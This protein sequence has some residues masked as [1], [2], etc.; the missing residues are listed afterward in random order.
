VACGI[1]KITYDLLLFAAF[2]A[3]PA[4]GERAA[5]ATERPHA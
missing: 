4:P 5:M 1:L 3:R 2:R